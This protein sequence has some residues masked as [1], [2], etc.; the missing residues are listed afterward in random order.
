M[1]KTLGSQIRE[2]KKD[3]L[4]TPVF[5]ILE[6]I[7]ETVIPLLM[8]FIIDDGVEKGDI[9]HIY[10]VGAAMVLIAALG[11]LFGVLGG[12]YGARASSGF[13][14]NLRKAMYENIQTFSFSNIDKY[15]TAGLVT[16]LTTDVTNIQN[17]YHPAYVCARTVQHDLRDGDGVCDQR[18]TGIGLSDS[19]D[20][21]WRM[22][23]A[24]HPSGNKIF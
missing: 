2:Y 11:L 14:R 19:G 4:L 24:H 17:A 12:K 3:S 7:M 8:A 13:A 16:R 18:E 23:C 10:M 1:L 22:P 15:S 20:L 5:M 6:V 21:S 9:H